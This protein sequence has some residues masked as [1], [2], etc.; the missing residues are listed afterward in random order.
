MEEGGRRREERGDIIRVVKH[1]LVIVAPK[2]CKLGITHL[3]A[4]DGQ[5]IKSQATDIDHRL[6]HLATQGYLLAQIDATVGQRM[7]IRP[8]SLHGRFLEFGSCEV[9]AFRQAR[10]LPGHCTNP[11][12]PP[13]IRRLS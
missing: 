8:G 6:A 9:S 12:C 1:R 11:L 7:D 4:I 2:G 3:L 5:H 10:L 13:E